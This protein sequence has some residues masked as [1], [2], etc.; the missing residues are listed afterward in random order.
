MFFGWKVVAGGFTAQLFVVGFLT[1]A[2][3]LL[4]TP[5]QDEFGVSLE[6]VMYSLTGATFLGLFMQPM[7][8]AMIDRFSVRGIMIAGSLLYALGLYAVSLASS[9]GQYIAAFA[10]TMALANALV[11]SMCSSALVSRWFVASRGRALGIAALGTSVGGVLVPALISYWLGTVGWRGAVENLALCVLL[12]M[13]PVVAL[14][15][16]NYPA[17]L[18]LHPEGLTE[19]PPEAGSAG[20]PD[21][22]GILRSPAFW[23]LGLALGLLFSAYSAVL[24]NISPYA[25]NLGSSKEQASALIMAVAITGFI[26][27]ILFGMAADRFS[28]K[29]ALWTA[30]AL[31]ALSFVVLA[32]QPGH[33]GMLLGAS[34]LGLAA[35]GMLPVWGAMMAQLF[36]LGSYGRAMGL[37]GPIITLCV[38]PGFAIVG[39]MYDS[40]GS[41]TPSLYLFTGVCAVSA[42]LLL[43]LKLP[44]RHG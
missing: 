17:D 25:I 7:A 13:L 15:I 5:V 24:A 2:V 30:Q 1:Y 41:Y 37:M 35:G 22:R 36:G 44:A 10:L 29:T 32:Q 26:G 28:L 43:P 18:G 21:M 8:G 12:V 6:Q 4:V 31:V 20:D 14:T 23:L 3:S 38:M 27:K 42:L 19:A 39:R 16:R 40:L 33:I 9:I 34:I 11:G